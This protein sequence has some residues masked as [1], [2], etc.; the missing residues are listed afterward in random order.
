MARAR[1]SVEAAEALLKDRYHE[2]AASRAYYAMFYAAQA[3]LKS[4]GIQRTKHSAV[5]AALGESFAKAG[6]LDAEHYR[7]FRDARRLRERADYAI[8]E[9]L[10]AG[11]ARKR[12]DAATRFV[13][14]V[15]RL[16]V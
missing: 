1:R 7:D 13:A 3:L 16:L 5:E 2:E 4:E 10:E 8:L 11:A 12:L 9:Q 6:R 14:E 15:E